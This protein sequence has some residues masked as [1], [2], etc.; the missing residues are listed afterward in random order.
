MKYRPEIDGLR[1]LAVLPVMLF[2]ARIP[3]FD[4]GFVGVDV[5]FVISGYLITSIIRSDLEKDRFS[6]IT[7]YERRARRILPALFL[8][9]ACCLPAAWFWLWPNDLKAF[10]ESV[11]AVALFSS[12][13]L[14]LHQ[15]G[16]FDT[17][18]I[19]PLLHTWSLAV[20][21][22]FYVLFPLLLFLAWRYARKWLVPSIAV[23]ALSSLLLADWGSVENP[24]AT[25]FLLPTRAWELAL[26]AWVAF[27][28]AK[29]SQ[30]KVGRRA[31]EV[32]SA[33]G[34]AAVVGAVF[35]LDESTPFP[36]RYALLPA[37]GTA[38]VILF[39]SPG[40]I[41][42]RYL[43]SKPLVAVGLIS[44]SAYLWHQ[45]I[46]SFARE[47]S[48]E[49]LGRAVPLALVGLSLGLAYL[50]WKYVEIP[51]RDR[52]RF[53]RRQVF[54]LAAMGSVIFF[55]L[56]IVG[57]QANGFADR[58]TPEERT[59]LSY[60]SYEDDS[61]YWRG[62]CFLL[63]EQS[64]DDFAR[65]CSA[66]AA[67]G[68]LIWGDSHAAALSFGLRALSKDLV[69]YAG[70]G[71]PPLFD[72][73][74]AK[75]PHCREFDDY[76]RREIRRIK[77]H[78]IFMHANW[79]LYGTLVS[80]ESVER[81]IAI[82]HG[83]SP[84]SQV[85]VVGS[86]PHWHRQLPKLILRKRTG[87]NGQYYLSNELVDNLREYDE[88]LR[89]AALSSDA[90]FMSPIDEMCGAKGCLATIEYE[91]TVMPT[92]WDESHLTTGASV[93]LAGRILEPRAAR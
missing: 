47:L 6:I 4:G 27:H 93:F 36:G 44:Y 72:V 21:E 9:V 32:I 45:P 70:T 52:T 34:L 7:F 64:V 77:P 16:Y 5:F 48:S 75:R 65:A 46:L 80:R 11:A 42:R 43:G 28:L 60:L 18:E 30:P 82:V 89:T 39:A 76:I 59:L 81:T 14:F 86:V 79:M 37:C 53:T 55:G 91:G 85:V 24:E 88:V 25:F 12:N 29:S 40:T 3:G 33:A 74:R 69:E 1:A 15:S 87:L 31:A 68:D 90:D 66:T 63:P 67:G 35:W 49:P 10:S 19:K 71:C 38:L 51:F 73:T 23:I 61:D 84:A 78:R 17:A 41:V 56:G 57:H 2:H 50:S 83:L 22:Q 92:T 8:V 62:S 54:T 58:L 20:E 13:V 26:G